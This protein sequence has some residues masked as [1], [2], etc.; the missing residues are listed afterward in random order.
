MMETQN[1]VDQK[2]KREQGFLIQKYFD[3]G[4]D[5]VFLMERMAVSLE[6][7]IILSVKKDGEINLSWG[8]KNHL[9]LHK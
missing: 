3:S 2:D 4:K 7:T 5:I 1:I 8:D 6:E 9:I